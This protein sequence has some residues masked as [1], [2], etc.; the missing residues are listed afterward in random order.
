[1]RR[2]WSIPLILFCSSTFLNAK[3]IAR[4]IPLS[5]TTV[6]VK[7]RTPNVDVSTIT[8]RISISIKRPTTLDPVAWDSSST[9]KVTI[10]FV[11]DGT[12]HAS[13]GK[14][15]GGIRV[16]R[17]GE[18]IPYYTLKYS[19][20]YMYDPSTAKKFIR[21]GERTKNNS[22]SAYLEIE[23]LR[24]TINSQIALGSTTE[25]DAPPQIVHNSVAF[26]A[27]TDASEAA[28][29]GSV[30]LSHTATGTNLAA[31]AGGGASSLTD[32]HTASVTYA[33]GSMTEDWDASYSTSFN[34]W[35][36]HKTVASG[37]NNVIL[38]AA[39]DPDELGFG[40]ITMTGVHQTTPVGS[41][42][43]NVLGLANSSVTVTSVGTDDLVVD[44]Y[45][46]QPTASTGTAQ[47]TRNAEYSIGGA[48]FFFQST[49]LGSDGGVMSWTSASGN[50]GIGAIAFKPAAVYTS[51]QEGFAFGDDDGNEAAHTLGTQDT[52][53]SSVLGTKTLRN[54]VNITGT[55]ASVTPSLRYQKNGAGGY[56]LVPTESITAMYTGSMEVGDVTES[57][58]N[59]ASASW[60]IS[61]P[62]AVSGDLLLVNLGWDDSTDVANVSISSGPNGEVP[63]T[64]SATVAP[65]GTQV[66]AK[67][68][69]FV[70]TGTW[71]IATIVSTPTANEQWTAVVVKVPAGEFDSSTPIG[72]VGSSVS[73]GIGNPWTAA[74]SAG[75]SDGQGRVVDWVVGDTDDPD[76]SIAGWTELSSVDRGAVGANFMVRNT[77]T[78]DSEVIAAQSGLTLP[79]PTNWCTIGYIVRPPADVTNHVYISASANVAAGGEDTTARLA[80]PATKATSD[81]DTGRRWDNENG[82]DAVAIGD[83]E[84]TEYEWVLTT[85]SPATTDDYFEFKTYMDGSAAT[86][87]T[88]TPKWTIA[89]AGGGTPAAV[90]R[91]RIIIAE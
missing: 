28:G 10:G 71:G 29:E 17:L 55:G 19:P 91:R 1:M 26:D 6:G 63:I 65:T 24:G 83:D 11:V 60:A 30:T 57:G 77:T 31:F 7:L 4:N 2:A 41:P 16:N 74:I 18:E 32:G 42:F 78:T 73:V 87:Y 39:G 44:N 52:N 90:M 68:W 46:G 66:R 84:Y 48:T 36:Y 76:G 14:V 40:V 89:S 47:T 67:A 79:T 15:T 38:T 23:L 25:S 8:D 72:V 33:G 70:A 43:T 56:A 51:D 50:H 54:L 61:V 59:T 49:Q 34:H 82:L 81:F 35:G 62:A 3:E 58:N 27:A 80:A 75:A 86:S 22:V 64:I 12:T 9:I 69:A 20:T 45:Y 53:N 85:Q 37:T 13:T 88:V 5:I 21:I